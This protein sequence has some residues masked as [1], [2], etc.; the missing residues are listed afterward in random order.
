LLTWNIDDLFAATNNFTVSNIVSIN[1][2]DVTE[3]LEKFALNELSDPD[4]SFNSILWNYGAA[5]SSGYVRLSKLSL[6]ELTSI[7]GV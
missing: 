3:Y 6:Y 5:P 4:A 2:R 7:Q 1:G